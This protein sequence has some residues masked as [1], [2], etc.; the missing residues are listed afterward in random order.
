MHPIWQWLCITNYFL[1]C[2]NCA[3]FFSDGQIM[4]SFNHKL[5]FYFSHFANFDDK[6]STCNKNPCNHATMQNNVFHYIWIKKRKLPNFINYSGCKVLLV[7][8]LRYW[9]APKCTLAF[10]KL[11]NTKLFELSLIFFFCLST[12]RTCRYR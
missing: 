10:H 11:L 9:N 7:N 1:L 2:F 12:T 6:Y 8:S 5:T 4:A 3:Y